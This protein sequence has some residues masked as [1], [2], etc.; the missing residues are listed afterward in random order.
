MKRLH[1]SIV[2]SL[3]I[4]THFIHHY[5]MKNVK[6]SMFIYLYLCVMK[7]SVWRRKSLTSLK[8]LIHPKPPDQMESQEECSS[9]QPNLLHHLSQLYSI[10]Q[11]NLANYQPIGKYPQSFR[12]PKLR[13]SPT[14]PKT[15]GQ[16]RYCLVIGKAHLQR[17]M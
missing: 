12:Y 11:S 7:F 17:G 10:S 14:I 4:L 8:I 13:S 5:L 15:I 6:I 1:C 9:R 16:N 3:K 2:L